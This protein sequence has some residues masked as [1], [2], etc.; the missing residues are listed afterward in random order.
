LTKRRIGTL[1]VWLAV[2]ATALVGRLRRPGPIVEEEHSPS[3]PLP[4]A[5]EA[6]P[7]APGP[8]TVG[9]V[10]AALARAFSGCV[11]IRAEESGRVTGDF[12][13]DGSE[14][15]AI[16]VR[17]SAERGY[18]INDA[19]RNW[20]VQDLGHEMAGRSQAP[21]PRV[22][23]EETLLAVIHGHGPAGWRNPEA[24]QAYLLKHAAMDK[25][26]VVRK[27][28]EARATSAGPLLRGDA[29]VDEGAEAPTRFLHWAGAR[30]ALWP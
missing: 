14:D 29:I 21:Q 12:N 11:E 17:P 9:D 6:V 25:L 24:R 7:A 16:V 22:E 13:G 1:V 28:K 20:I 30:Y 8:S 27:E 2:A 23:K 5:T 15:V 18:E 26:R 3:A 19:F 10:H 4:S